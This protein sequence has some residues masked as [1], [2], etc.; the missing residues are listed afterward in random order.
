MSVPVKKIR[1]FLKRQHAEVLAVKREHIGA[2]LAAVGQHKQSLAKKLADWSSDDGK[3]NPAKARESKSW[4][5]STAVALGVTTARAMRRGSE[6][7]ADLATDHAQ[8]WA[9]FAADAF[10]D[11]L[12]VGDSSDFSI[13]D[14]RLSDLQASYVGTA[15]RGV[16]GTLLK[17]ATAV[18]AGSALADFAQYIG[19]DSAD[20]DDV[21][22]AAFDPVES[23]TEMYI[24]TETGDAYG[25][26]FA[27]V[28]SDDKAVQKRWA[29]IDPGC[30]SICHDADGQVQDMDDD[31][32]MGDGST[33]DFPP[34]HPN[35]DCTWLPWKDD[36]GSL[37]ST[38]DVEQV[39]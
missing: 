38:D 2:G 31:F 1:R 35:C 22:A 30:D 7:A 36:W 12:D 25:L 23:R 9:S 15:R 10:G 29:T 39:A 18:A 6:D 19:A 11:D 33:C 14:D 13:D 17:V 4:A 37:K 24:R 5:A 32:E 27:D 20:H 3:L 34:A 28:L 21:A 26:A 16:Y 8:Q